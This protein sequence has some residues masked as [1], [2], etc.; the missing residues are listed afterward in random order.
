MITQAQWGKAGALLGATQL[1]A[2]VQ[3]SNLSILEATRPTLKHPLERVPPAASQ[4]SEILVLP[5]TCRAWPSPAHRRRS[6]LKFESHRPREGEG[7]AQGHTAGL[8]QSWREW[9]LISRRALILC[10]N[11]GEEEGRCERLEGH[12][13]EYGE[14]EVSRQKPSLKFALCLIPPHPLSATSL[15]RGTGT[16]K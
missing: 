10:L 7:L 3:E 11:S 9:F 12:G 13:K 16:R 4:I 5:S 8:R 14:V 6:T 15:E 2:G 1:G